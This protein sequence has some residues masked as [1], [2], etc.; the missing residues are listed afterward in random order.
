MALC[1]HLH[2]CSFIHSLQGLGVDVPGVTERATKLDFAD[3][4]VL[5]AS[6]AVELQ[7]AP[8]RMSAW[9]DLHEMEFGVK[10]CGVMVMHGPQSDLD[11]S[12][13]SSNGKS[14][15][16]SRAIVTWESWWIQR[17]M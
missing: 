13:R 8:K 5:L 11:I 7:E 12:T 1:R 9:G 17:S 3:D 4:Q 14:C 15:Q 10:K 6:S 16:E 2:R